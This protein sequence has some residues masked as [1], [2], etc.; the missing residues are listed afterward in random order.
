MEIF[1][2][3]ENAA[4]NLQVRISSDAIVGSNVSLNDK[5]IRKSSSYGFEVPL[6]EAVDLDGQVLSSVSNFFVSRNL[7]EIFDVTSVKFVL[8]NGAKSKVIDARKVKID[9]NI[10]MGYMVIQLVQNIER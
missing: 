1:E 5:L 6:G 3:T 8:K 9:G 2:M 10:S 7:D 4:V